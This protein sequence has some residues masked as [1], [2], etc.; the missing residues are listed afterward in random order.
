MPYRLPPDPEEPLRLQEL[1]REGRR[2]MDTGIGWK[3]GPLRFPR[4]AWVYIGWTI[5]FRLR[6]L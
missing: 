1:E 3:L 6:A 2:W 5:R 4:E